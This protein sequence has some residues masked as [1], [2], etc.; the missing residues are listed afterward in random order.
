MLR[1][2]NLENECY[3]TTIPLEFAKQLGLKKGCYVDFQLVGNSVV[4]TKE[5]EKAESPNTGI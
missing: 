5:Q 2:I 3:R 4:I 1:K